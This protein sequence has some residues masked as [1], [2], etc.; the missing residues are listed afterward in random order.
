MALGRRKAPHSDKGKKRKKKDS[1]KMFKSLKNLF[2]TWSTGL[3]ACTLANL[4]LLYHSILSR[5]KPVVKWIPDTAQGWTRKGS[6]RC[7]E[8]P[9]T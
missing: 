9:L 2:G 4:I 3:N 7:D 5:V 8:Q 6:D 1:L